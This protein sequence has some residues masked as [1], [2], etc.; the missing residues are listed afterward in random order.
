MHSQHLHIKTAIVAVTSIINNIIF[1]QKEE[2]FAGNKI[3]C[4]QFSR[5]NL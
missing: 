3:P 2:R 4:F 5:R 1:T